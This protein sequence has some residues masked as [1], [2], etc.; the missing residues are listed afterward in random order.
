MHFD[1]PMIYLSSKSV[2]ALVGGET[3]ADNRGALASVS[4]EAERVLVY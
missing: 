2:P 4:D 1:V 3:E